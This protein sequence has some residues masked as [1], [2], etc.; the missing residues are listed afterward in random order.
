M[1]KACAGVGRGGGEVGGGD[2][3]EGGKDWRYPY[4]FWGW[5]SIRIPHPLPPPS[6]SVCIISGW[7]NWCSVLRMKRKHWEVTC[8]RA[9]ALA[10]F[11]RNSTSVRYEINKSLNSA[12]LSQSAFLEENDPNC[13]RRKMGNQNAYQKGLKNLLSQE[14]DFVV[15]KAY[16]VPK[17]QM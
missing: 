6:S 4:K 2:G 10:K 1:K 9:D 14:M 11:R 15:K 13:P 3:G 7:W 8:A 17:K 12:A 16:I 5:I